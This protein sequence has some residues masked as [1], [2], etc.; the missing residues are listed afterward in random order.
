MLFPITNKEV[1]KPLFLCT[2]HRLIKNTL[3]SCKSPH[4]IPEECCAYVRAPTL[5]IVGV[6]LMR[7]SLLHHCTEPLKVLYNDRSPS[8]SPV[9]ESDIAL[10]CECMPFDLLA[11]AGLPPRRL[12]S[13]EMGRCGNTEDTSSPFKPPVNA[14]ASLITVRDCPFCPQPAQ[15]LSTIEISPFHGWGEDASIELHQSLEALFRK[16]G[17]P[18]INEI[19]PLALRKANTAFDEIRR[20]IRG[21]CSI[22]RENP[23]LLSNA[24]LFTLFDAAMCLPPDRSA[25]LLSSILNEMNAFQ[26]EKSED[27]PP[28]LVHSSFMFDPSILDEIEE[29]G[30]VVAEDD[31]CNGRRQFDL[32]HNPVSPYL[33]Y[34]ILHNFSFKPLCPVFRSA[35]ERFELLYKLLRNYGISTVVFLDYNDDPARTEQ[36]VPLRKK[37]MRSGI[38]PVAIKPG[39]ARKMMRA[40]LDNAAR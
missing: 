11:S 32:S 5:S 1:S 15:M 12:R 24:D 17:L 26:C 35:D 33:Y 36:M 22:R 7:E 21:I 4:Y 28:V 6:F 18:D 27:L 13:E 20:L 23:R 25:S 37:L 14:G 8:S 9:N 40:Y 19:D 3:D 38:D 29:A 2:R 16:L 34:E 39:D 10:C 30:C 31:C